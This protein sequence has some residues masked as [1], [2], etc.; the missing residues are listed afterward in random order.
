MRGIS[1][2]LKILHV[3]PYF[4]PAWNF[5]GPVRA[6]YELSKQ[7]VQRGHEVT[8]V[9]T[10]VLDTSNR[11]KIKNEIIDGIN[12]KR[13][14]NISK[15]LASS[16]KIFISLGMLLDAIKFKKFD[17]IHLH[18][19]PTM[20]NILF[21]RLCKNSNIPYVIQAHGSAGVYLNKGA[22]KHI[23]DSFWGY[24]I[25]SDASSVIAVTQKEAEQYAHMGI[26]VNK[27]KILPNG[28]DLSHYTNLPRKGTFRAKY[29][30]DKNEF[31]I[32]YL[33]RINQ[34]KGIDLLIK[35]FTKISNN[36]I[37]K[38]RLV[39]AGPDDGYLTQIKKL[40]QKKEIERQV[41]ITGP[42]YDTDKL[43]SYVDAD[44]YVLPSNY[45]IFG[46]TVLEACACGTPVIVTDRCGISDIVDGRLGVAVPYSEDKLGIAIMDILNNKKNQQ[47]FRESGRLLVSQEFS[48]KRI[49]EQYEILCQQC[50]DTRYVE[51]DHSHLLNEHIR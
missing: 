42:L 4:V 38:L 19:Y 7:L 13:Y 23:F 32:L 40:I 21:H 35:A 16:H 27:I 26:N 41:V 22:I 10:D 3:I 6:C 31:M 9:T 18:D 1:T 44:V 45:E 51:M 15:N 46:I 20:Q 36:S 34:I 49:V 17:I 12:I 30:I 28:I 37:K 5:G 48:W 25:L 24:K 14:R 39:I 11:I 50:I 29:E 43:E 2:K 8:V 33:G 47:L